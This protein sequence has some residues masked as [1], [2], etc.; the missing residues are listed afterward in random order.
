LYFDVFDAAKAPNP[1]GAKEGKEEL[2]KALLTQEAVRKILEELGYDVEALEQ[3]MQANPQQQTIAICG[4][5]AAP[6]DRLRGVF[7]SRKNA[8]LGEGVMCI[9]GMRTVLQRDGAAPPAIV[10]IAEQ[11][12]TKRFKDGFLVPWS[13]NT[14]ILLP[15]K[16]PTW[17][18]DDGFGAG[19][20][21]PLSREDQQ[22]VLDAVRLMPPKE[23]PNPGA[24]NRQRRPD[25][26]HILPLPVPM[27]VPALKAA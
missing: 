14:V 15:G 4:G 19:R 17:S 12:C 26:N 23:K 27:G 10:I 7:F 18:I 21:Q 1:T 20:L 24:G 25:V 8:D 3:A 9:R 6:I 13:E 2:E 11:L 5:E 16:E 22:A